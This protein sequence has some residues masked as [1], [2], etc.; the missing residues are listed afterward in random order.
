MAILSRTIGTDTDQ[1][2][3]GMC[4]KVW[5][6]EANFS[7]VLRYHRH[8]V[9]MICSYLFERGSLHEFRLKL[10]SCRIPVIPSLS[11][12]N[13]VSTDH[14]KRSSARAQPTSAPKTNNKGSP[15]SQF[16]LG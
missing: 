16:V 9:P 2:G 5:H 1:Y 7:E 14:G 11:G 13:R 15:H 6:L 10:V 12:K 3:P 8:S 4:L